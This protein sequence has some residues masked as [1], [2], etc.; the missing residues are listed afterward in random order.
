MFTELVRL[1]KDAELENNA[2]PETCC[3]HAA[4]DVGFGDKKKTSGS[5]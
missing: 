5:A 4:Y 1:G 3:R 2:V